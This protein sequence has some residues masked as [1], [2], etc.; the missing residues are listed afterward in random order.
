MFYQARED[1]TA[2]STSSSS[3]P[4]TLVPKDQHGKSSNYGSITDISA[5][6]NSDRV[7]STAALHGESE[8]LSIVPL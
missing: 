4:P 8:Y 6:Q 5:R 2:V 7:T 3:D 1:I